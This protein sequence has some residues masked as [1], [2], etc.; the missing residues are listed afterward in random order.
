MASLPHGRQACFVIVMCD[1]AQVLEGNEVALGSKRLVIRPHRQFCNDAGSE[2]KCLSTV[3]GLSGWLVVGSPW[4]NSRLSPAVRGECLVKRQN[5][6]QPSIGKET[7]GQ[8]SLTFAVSTMR[9]DPCQ[10]CLRWR[11]HMSYS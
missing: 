11:V 7:L 4:S 2:T 10:D 5:G 3:G 8:L 1:A 9:C 6:F